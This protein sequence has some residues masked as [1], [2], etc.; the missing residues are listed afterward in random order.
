MLKIIGSYI[1]VFLFAG[2]TSYFIHLFLLGEGQ[3]S[4]IPILQKAYMLHFGFSLILLIA[5][6]LLAHYNKLVEQLGMLYM[7]LL[8]FKIIIFASLF[9]PQLL[10]EAMLPRFYRASLLIPVIV[11]LPLEVIL[12]SKIMQGKKA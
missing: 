9:Y 11:F 8:V 1:V 7:A 12:I 4:F 2:A 10:G 3:D 5:F 6:H